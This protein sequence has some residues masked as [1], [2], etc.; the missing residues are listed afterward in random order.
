MVQIVGR[1]GV[2]PFVIPG[3]RYGS[4]FPRIVMILPIAAVASEV[5]RGDCSAAGFIDLVGG[6]LDRTAAQWAF[7]A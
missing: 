6:M 3:V 4:F 1:L 7:I 2:V 5:Y